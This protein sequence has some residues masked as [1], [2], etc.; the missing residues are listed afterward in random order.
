MVNP[1][2]MSVAGISAY[3]HSIEGQEEVADFIDWLREQ[4]KD[5]E[6]AE[7]LFK[8]AEVNIEN[9][10]HE[11]WMKMLQQL[12]RFINSTPPGHDPGHIF[13]DL[14]AALALAGDSFVQKAAYRSD[15]VAGQIAGAFHDIGNAVT[16]RYEDTE[17]KVGHGEIGAWLFFR[18]VDL[19][20][21][22]K[23]L[24][25]YS[26]AAH[27]HY[28]KPTPVKVPEGFIRQK[29]WYELWDTDT[30]NGQKPKGFFVLLGRFA[31]RLDTNGVTLL[32][33][34]MLANADAVESSSTA[35]DLSADGFYEIKRE[36][37]KV[38]LLPEIR[39]FPNTKTPTAIEHVIN[40]FAAS[41]FGATEY[42]QF[43]KLFPLMSFLVRKKVAGAYGVW[44]TLDG[45]TMSMEDVGQTP[46][47]EIRDL[48]KA[49]L[50]EISCS[51][52]FERA[53]KVLE[54]AWSE[55]SDE[56]RFKWIAGLKFVQKTYREWIDILHPLACESDKELA[57]SLR[58][59]LGV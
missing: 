12:G 23:I 20:E 18:I 28:L 52:N 29:Y 26:I 33:R 53:W 45:T 48:F 6:S 46:Y 49:T 16:H 47:W 56:D 44:N 40:T 3:V 43:D 17:R 14:L 21:P 25:A 41:N 39:M 36:D 15:V 50:L 11:S 7:A 5:R 31:D 19:D 34:H 57:D 55:L 27:V 22:L 8:S 4:A 37:L 54:L 38:M 24:A 35:I 51:K 30:A 10:G 59:K 2:K 58:A 32:T 9:F 13:R 1:K 42:S